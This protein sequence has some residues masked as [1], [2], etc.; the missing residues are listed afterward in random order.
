MS[1]IP[2][3]KQVAKRAAACKLSGRRYRSV[4]AM[5][6]AECS[7]EFQALYFKQPKGVARSATRATKRVCA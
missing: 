3:L 2:T 4:D 1:K 7:P 6:R 5:V